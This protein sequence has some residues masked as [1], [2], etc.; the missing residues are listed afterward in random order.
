MKLSNNTIF[1][2]G[3]GSGIGLAL[4]KTFLDFKNTVVI[5]GRNLEKLEAVRNK[6]PEIHTIC[7][8]ITKEDD[9]QKALEQIKM[10]FEDLNVL[11]NNAGIMLNY[12]FWEDDNALKKMEDE[13]GINLVG[14]LKL[15]KLFLPILMNQPESALINV[16]SG[17]GVFPKKS[18]PVYCATKAAVHIFSKSLR[19]QLEKTPVKVFEIIPPLVDT[20]MTKG[21]GGKK[22]SPEALAKEVITSLERDN[23]EIRG[24]QVK[25][26][27][28][29]NR[30]LPSIIEKIYKKK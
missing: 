23:Y 9:I 26:L 18:A 3:G 2:T 1:I 30:F 21:R 20:E 6:Y 7:C 24:G 19:Y 25:M 28:L 10:E 17:L 8:D 22:I 16:S 13:I 14:L 27:L 4:A 29:I 12:N 5:C 15:T 11:V